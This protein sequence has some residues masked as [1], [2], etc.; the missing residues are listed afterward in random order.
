M[1]LSEILSEYV[2]ACFSGIWICSHE[3]DDAL[4]EIA[5]LC[6]QQSWSLATWDI[7]AGLQRADTPH[8]NE[9][10][11]TTQ[12]PL[13]AIRAINA[14]ATPDGAALLVLQNFHRFLGS[15]EIV[16]EVARQ[17]TRGKQN[18]TFLIVLAPV[19]QLPPELERLFIVVDHELP[20]RT[21]L[22][23]IARGIATEEG[24]LPDG[25]ELERVL[26]AAA[27]LTRFEVE[28]AFCLS[29]VR[30]G[31]L[32]P[33]AIWQLKA[34]ALTKS[35]LLSLH[36]GQE[37][38]DTLGGLDALKTFCLRALRPRLERSSRVKSRGVL[39]LGVPGT[40]KS[41]FAKSLGQ[42]TQRPTLTLDVGALLGS[43][44]GQ[45]EERTRRALDIVDRMQ[46]AVLFIDEVE[47]ALSGASG[48]GATDSGVSTRMLG[49]LLTWLNDH[50]SDVF[51]I[52]TAND[53]SRLPPEFA[54][55]ERFDALF[56][57]DLPGPEQ[58]R[59]I[60]QLYLRQ[61]AL[62]IDQRLP[63]DTDWTGAEIRACARLSALLDLPLV[64]AAQYIVPVATTAAEAVARLRSWAHGRCLSADQPGVYRL[65]TSQP[66]RLRRRI[67]R[68]PSDN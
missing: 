64:E 3:H 52:C 22:E 10:S 45:T 63:S 60:W 66:N 23:H 62:D 56:F 17:I 14:L 4:R 31:C 67:P 20:D 40:G 30:R 38:F 15:A 13:A 24:E 8:E 61:F 5:Q 44:V 43:L 42:E 19:V 37:S 47:K 49:T 36:H 54:R 65:P 53:V 18:R 29:L 50:E 46:P 41:A 26:D 58:R 12:D 33:S 7:G 9:M 34:Q 59:A 1:A 11:A 6:Q 51:V 21:Q 68:G 55:C 28:G 16:Q 2:R 32:E 48:A 35:G 57:L 25:V 27:G 39:L